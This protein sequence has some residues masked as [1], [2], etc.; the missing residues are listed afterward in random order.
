MLSDLTTDY[1]WTTEL[2]S[3]FGKSKQKLEIE[4]NQ[5]LETK[6][7]NNIEKMK[8]EEWG[9]MSS[10]KLIL[11]HINKVIDNNMDLTWKDY[12]SLV[13]NRTKSYDAKIH[14]NKIIDHLITLKSL[15]GWTPELE[16]IF[17][18][19]TEKDKL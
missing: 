15:S 3:I 7:K 18:N 11:R 13:F 6:K 4:F 2:N 12:S 5:L 10:A 14:L 17:G 8:T 1:R 19:L 16:R 9:E